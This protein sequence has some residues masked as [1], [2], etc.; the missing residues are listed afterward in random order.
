MGEWERCQLAGL[1]MVCCG[2]GG[3]RFDPT[4]VATA[5]A[6]GDGTGIGH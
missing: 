1:G 2:G 3:D 4:A 6:D 5:E